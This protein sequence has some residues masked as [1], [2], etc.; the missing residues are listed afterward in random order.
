M[1]L[2]RLLFYLCDVQY[3]LVATKSCEFLVTRFSWLVYFFY[4]A[5]FLV[6]NQRERAVHISFAGLV[7]FAVEIGEF[8][9]EGSELECLEHI[10]DFVDVEVVHGAL[11]EVKVDVNRG[12]QADKLAT[13]FHT[14]DSC[15]EFFGDSRRNLV[16]ICVDSVDRLEFLQ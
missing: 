15:G 8:L 5:T 12:G 10:H 14:G 11:V 4:T 9:D 13:H 16:E 2:N 7:V 1:S 6:K 3:T